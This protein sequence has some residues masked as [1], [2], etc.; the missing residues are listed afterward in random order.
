[1]EPHEPVP[2]GPIT[3]R[4]LKIT[5]KMLHEYG[6]TEGCPQCSHIRAFGEAKPGL[7]HSE[8]CRQ[9]LMEALGSTAE[10]LLD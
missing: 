6:T 5:R 9:R 7:N 1:M 8:K 4:R 3:A 2:D 10:G